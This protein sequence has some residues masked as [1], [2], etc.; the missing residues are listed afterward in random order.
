MVTRSLPVT[1]YHVV[2]LPSV[3]SMRRTRSGPKVPG[4]GALF[5]AGSAGGTRCPVP[6]A[7]PPPT[8]EN[9]SGPEYRAWS[10]AGGWGGGFGPILRGV[11]ALL[12]SAT[13]RAG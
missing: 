8:S 6:Q 13:Y 4:A 12:G 9:W 10:A 11:P 7:A 3:R 5:D 1:A 2:T